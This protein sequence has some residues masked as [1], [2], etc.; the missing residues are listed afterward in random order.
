[1]GKCMK[2]H[3]AIKIMISPSTPTPSLRD[4]C[5]G[6]LNAQVTLGVQSTEEYCVQIRSSDCIPINGRR[7]YISGF[8]AIFAHEVLISH[9]PNPHTLPS[10]DHNCRQPHFKFSHL[11]NPNSNFLICTTHKHALQFSAISERAQASGPHTS[12]IHCS[13]VVQ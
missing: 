7:L 6:L 10:S 3:E 1:M 4:T 9:I 12:V 2:S 5:V 8:S 11:H 13:Y